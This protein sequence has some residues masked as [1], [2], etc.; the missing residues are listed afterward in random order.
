MLTEGYFKSK[1]YEIATENYI[2][3]LLDLNSDSM[4]EKFR[5][6]IMFSAINEQSG[7]WKNSKASVTQQSSHIH[8]QFHNCQFLFSLMQKREKDQAYPFSSSPGQMSSS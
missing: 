2:S 6:Q 4:T 7:C 5:F 8:Y 1:N 3:H